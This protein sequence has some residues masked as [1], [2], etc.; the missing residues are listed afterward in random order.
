M[1][2]SDLE[3]GDWLLAEGEEGQ[4]DVPYKVISL[5]DRWSMNRD[6]K[7]PVTIE[8]KECWWDV[9]KEDM[10]K[11]LPMPLTDEM[12]KANGFSYAPD[13][14]CTGFGRWKSSDLDWFCLEKFD[15]QDF[16][17][18]RFMDSFWSLEYVHTFQHLMRM[19][20]QLLIADNFKI[21]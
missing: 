13:P 15:D 5:N 7:C 21:Q 11:L 14:D 16:W 17:S 18:F 20:G 19:V 1:H 4:G 9:D 12:L 10:G 6:G 2:E 8:S 3:I